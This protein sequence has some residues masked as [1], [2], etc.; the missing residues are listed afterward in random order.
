MDKVDHRLSDCAV[1]M[2]PHAASCQS[3]PF[4]Y[5]KLHLC[6]QSI[7]LL[8]FANDITLIGHP[9]TRHLTL[10]GLNSLKKDGYG[11]QKELSLTCPHH[12]V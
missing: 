12:P 11:F 2:F 3:V 8:T 6:H 4:P 7:K 5:Q 10:L 9:L 1:V